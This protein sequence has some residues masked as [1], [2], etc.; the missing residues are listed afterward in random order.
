MAVFS[1][2]PRSAALASPSAHKDQEFH[3]ISFHHHNNITQTFNFRYFI[4]QWILYSAD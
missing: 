3:L 1:A 2:T 4:S